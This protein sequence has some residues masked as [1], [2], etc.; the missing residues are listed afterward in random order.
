MLPVTFYQHIF[1]SSDITWTVTGLDRFCQPKTVEKKDCA[2]ASKSM[3]CVTKRKKTRTGV[4]IH[5]RV[6]AYD[7][8]CLLMRTPRFDCIVCFHIFPSGCV[9][10]S[11]YFTPLSISRT[12]GLILVTQW[13]NVGMYGYMMIP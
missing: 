10:C 4:Q 1:W 5:V 3:G 8:F 11:R 7:E 13:M 9:G 6:D 12:N 2:S